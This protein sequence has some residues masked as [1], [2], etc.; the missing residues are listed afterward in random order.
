[1]RGPND[2]SLDLHH[3][4]LGSWQEVEVDHVY[5]AKRVNGSQQGSAN[6]VDGCLLDYCHFNW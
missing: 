2:L 3:D 4:T 6:A 5:A 1:M